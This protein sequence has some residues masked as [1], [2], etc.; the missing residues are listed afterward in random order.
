[1]VTFHKGAEFMF[2]KL[3]EFF[4]LGAQKAGTTTLH[5][6]L[7]RH[8]DIC[9]PRIKETHYFSDEQRFSRGLDWYFH[10]F[11]CKNQRSAIVGEIDP[12][13]MYFEHAPLRIR[14]VV[15]RPKLIFI[16][17]HPLER[18]YS[19]YLMSVRRG[20]ENLS[21]LD[22]LEAETKRLAS[23]CNQHAINHQSYLS[24]GLYSRQIALFKKTFPDSQYL[25]IKFDDMISQI[26][27]QNIFNEICLFIGVRAKHATIIL[28]KKS[29][30]ASLPRF[31]FLRDFLYKQSY[32]RK[33][34]GKLI[35]SKDVKLR[36]AL[37][38]DKLNQR[39]D[40]SLRLPTDHVIPLEITRL[41]KTEI[42]EVQRVT[43]L[44][45]E[46]WLLR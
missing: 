5:D 9:L 17:R 26:T 3:P 8:P 16:L 40:T 29:N 34:L 4:V 10:Q 32:W 22:A 12:D 45:C 27:G 18:A 42:V 20:Y 7:S 24:R 46:D 39:P 25:F 31:L 19:H 33:A 28:D 11:Q 36:I 41:I 1:M 43:G 30:Q 2:K 35:S 14:T 44:H 38:L 15:E 21:F 23:D 13:Y 6:L 37:L